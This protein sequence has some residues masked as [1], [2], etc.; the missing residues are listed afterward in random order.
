ML[1]RYVSEAGQFGFLFGQQPQQRQPPRRILLG[2][3]LS[4]KVFDVE[5]RDE[6]AL[7]HG[8]SPGLAKHTRLAAQQQSSD[9][10]AMA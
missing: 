2:S 3:Q 6:D 4:S 8:P 9:G 1:A 5:L 10:F 7:V